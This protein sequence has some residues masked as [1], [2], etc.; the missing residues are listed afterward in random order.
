MYS[1]NHKTRR[2]EFRCPDPSC[3]PYL[4]F[5]AILMAI[6]H[7]IVDSIHPGEALDKEA[8]APTPKNL[9]RAPTTPG[10]LVEAADAL[11]ADH[12]FLLRGNVFTPNMIDTW[13]RLTTEDGGGLQPVRRHAMSSASTP[14]FD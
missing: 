7:G 6:I 9:E 5:A 13:I 4:A 1:P 12:E 2:L 8:G 3:N 10:S 14:M 11:R